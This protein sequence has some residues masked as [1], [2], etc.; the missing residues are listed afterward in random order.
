MY[1]ATNK[2]EEGTYYIHTVNSKA[3]VDGVETYYVKPGAT[4]TVTL[5]PP[6]RDPSKPALKF[7]KW[8]I[9]DRWIDSLEPTQTFVMPD[10][11]V[12][13]MARYAEVSG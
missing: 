10:R 8:Q 5:D 3:W 12:W 11:D 6:R 9:L 2:Q 1:E 7:L 4:V 13:V